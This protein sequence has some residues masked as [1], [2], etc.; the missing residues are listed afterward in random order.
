ANG[1][2]VLR[3]DQIGGRIAFAIADLGD[4][5]GLIGTPL[6]GAVSGALVATAPD[7][8]PGLALDLTGTDLVGAGASVRRARVTARMRD[9]FGDRRIAADLALAGI[10]AGRLA[11]A[12]ANLSAT[13]PIDA[14]DVRLAASAPGFDRAR[15]AARA[16]LDAGASRVELS[17]L[18]A[19]WHGVTVRLL[20]PARI[21]YAPGLSVVRLRLGMQGAELTADGRIRPA[22]GLTLRLSNV[23]PTLIDPFVPGLPARGRLDATATLSGTLAAPTGRLTLRGRGLGLAATRAA[24][25]PP[26]A[27]TATA[28]LAGGRARIETTLSAGRATRLTL[29]GT[30]PLTP[31]GTLALA[32]KGG[33]DLAIVDPI[34]IAEGRRI[35][36]RLTLDARLGGTIAHPAIAGTAR[37]ARAMFADYA[38]GIDIRDIAGTVAATGDTIRIDRLQGRAGPGTIAV[39]GNVGVFAP[40]LPVNL[41]IAARD[42]ELPRSDLMT[43]RFDSD[44]AIHGSAHGRLSAGGTV[45]FRR[46]E[47]NIP[48]SM[49]PSLA[50]LR[51]VRAGASPPPRAML[52][53][54][55]A[56]ALTVSAAREIFVRGRGID[57]EFAGRIHIG[58]TAAN[59]VATGGFR[60]V[61]GAINM[62][63]K[64]L[65]FTEGRI[66]FN[67]GSPENPTLH[68]VA[69]NVT[70]STTATLTIGGTVEKPTVALSSAPVLPQDQVLGAL[71]FNGST[72]LSPFQLAELA[73]SLA[74]LTGAGPGTGDPLGALRNGLGLDQLSVGA[75]ASGS[76]TLQAGRYIGSRF[77]VG[78]TQSA[79]GGRQAD[80]EVNLTKR[81]RLNATIGTGIA[82]ASGASRNSGPSIGLKYQFHY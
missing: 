30:V 5:S 11:G 31:T 53:P 59:P 43:A 75:S 3:G 77:Y 8:P 48:E 20:G 26:A 62:A 81:L 57:A 16:R 24:G 13:G 9:P 1:A 39:S 38:T 44:L 47:I 36:G 10:A 49:P 79:T 6:G 19:A 2:I 29:S 17:T 61:R 72:A 67:G 71:F 78:A 25:L 65:V 28:D 54:N 70:G 50:R 45:R 41:T 82:N 51:V 63:G 14:L 15:L 23:T 52:R 68:L 76:P 58:G 35:E 42:A 22:L 64:T 33:V 27:L 40:D 56:L 21:G 4:F 55:V 69:T 12:E 60:M 66:G 34:L 46:V 37:L 7:G 74:T 73:S 80:V 32:A 18:T